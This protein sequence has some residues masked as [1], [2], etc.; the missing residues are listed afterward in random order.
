MAL[1]IKWLKAAKSVG[2]AEQSRARSRSKRMSHLERGTRS[3]V[4]E[5]LSLQ[6]EPLFLRDCA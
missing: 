1:K 4:K 5:S 2:Q 6:V 3:E